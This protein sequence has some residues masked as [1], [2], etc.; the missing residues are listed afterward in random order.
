MTQQRICIAKITT[1]HGIRGLVKMHVY[2]DDPQ[3]AQGA[4]YTTEHGTDTLNITLK[5]A[6]AKHW[7]ASI[8]GVTDR[9]QSELLRGTKLYI[10]QTALPDTNDGEFY[11]HEL[12]GLEARNQDNILVGSVIDVTN[13]GAS[14]LL[15]I[16]PTNGE[17]SFY[18]PFTDDTVP[19]INK[20]H[21]IIIIPEG[22]LG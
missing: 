2:S 22:L 14:D 15:E 20:D 10:D 16:Q 5:N 9:N 17:E 3:L 13:F 8:D 7:L 12:I 19:E 21:L 11:Q 1:A 18:L 4:L 6:T